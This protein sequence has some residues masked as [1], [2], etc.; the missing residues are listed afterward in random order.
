MCVDWFPLIFL[1]LILAVLIC[2]TLMLMIV[3]D[4]NGLNKFVISIFAIISAVSFIFFGRFV[5]INSFYTL[6]DKTLYLETIPNITNISD[7]NQ[8]L[9]INLKTDGNSYKK[10][11][12]SYIGNIEYTKIDEPQAYITCKARKYIS[13]KEFSTLEDV[14]VYYKE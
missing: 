9:Q 13:N 12:Y 7:S 8:I 10:V 4:I 2:C 5:I 3:A 11:S 14:H 6:E 1:I